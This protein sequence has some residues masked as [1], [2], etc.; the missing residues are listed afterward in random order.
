M[1]RKIT[2]SFLQSPKTHSIFFLN[3]KFAEFSLWDIMFR[4]FDLD[5]S[6]QMEKWETRDLLLRPDSTTEAKIFIEISV[7]VPRSRLSLWHV[8]IT[9]HCLL[10]PGP[11]WISALKLL[12]TPPLLC[13]RLSAMTDW[14]TYGNSKQSKKTE[15]GRTSFT[16]VRTWKPSNKQIYHGGF[17][18]MR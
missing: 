3:H 17:S 4:I 9:C 14:W 11:W 16:S 5:F 15:I 6:I 10:W 8:P 18:S 2:L 12:Q 1:Y 13:G 7:H